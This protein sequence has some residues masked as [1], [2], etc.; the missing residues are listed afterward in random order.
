MPEDGCDA[1]L[2]SEVQIKGERAKAFG[3][4]QIKTHI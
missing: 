2:G 3:D 4:V 1:I